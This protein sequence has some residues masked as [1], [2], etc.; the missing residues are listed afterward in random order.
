MVLVKFVFFINC[1]YEDDVVVVVEYLVLKVLVGELLELL[2]F[3]SDSGLVCLDEVVE[4]IQSQIVCVELVDDVCI[5][6]CVGSKC[7]SN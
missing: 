6:G 5:G 3:V 7:C 4:W 1:I 2:Y